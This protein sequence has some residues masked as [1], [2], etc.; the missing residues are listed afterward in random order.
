MRE[1]ESGDCVVEL[2]CVAMCVVLLMVMMVYDG[3]VC[4]CP[5]KDQ[6]CNC[7]W[8]GEQERVIGDGDAACCM[9]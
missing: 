6:S 9:R 3:V 8:C 7:E 5:R 1:A 4:V 2:L